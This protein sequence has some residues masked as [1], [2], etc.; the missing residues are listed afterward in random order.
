MFLQGS[1]AS[2]HQWCQQMI[3]LFLIL[4]ACFYKV[5]NQD[6]LE[7][8]WTTDLLQLLN[9]FEASSYIGGSSMLPYVLQIVLVYTVKLQRYL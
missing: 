4:G 2:L 1:E 6:L 8:L 7:A 9:M 5:I 3:C